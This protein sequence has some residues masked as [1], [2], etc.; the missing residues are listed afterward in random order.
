V[1][2]NILLVEAREKQEFACSALFKLYF[3]QSGV[4]ILLYTF[5]ITIALV[6]SLQYGPQSPWSTI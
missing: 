1:Q 6:G 5:R 4:Q 2:P 3:L